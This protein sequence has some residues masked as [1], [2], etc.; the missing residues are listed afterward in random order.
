MWCRTAAVALSCVF[1]GVGC[2]DVVVPSGQSAGSCSASWQPLMA[3]SREADVPLSY[4]DGN[5][6]YWSILQE[7]LVAL[8]VGGGAASPI[9]PGVGRDLVVEGN[10]FL[11]SSGRQGLQFFQA[12]LD[13]GTPTLLVD[14]AAGQGA[15][16]LS[17]WHAFT[18]DQIFWTQEDAVGSTSSVWH[19]RRDGG[20]ADL[21]ERLPPSGADVPSIPYWTP[22]VALGQDAVL[23]GNDGGLGV[24]VPFDGGPARA[25]AVPPVAS[26]WIQVVGVDETGV[27]WEIPKF[28]DGVKLA[29]TTVVLS[30][31]DGGPLRTFWDEVPANGWI[32]RIWP[33][34]AG[35]WIMIGRQKLDDDLRHTVVYA[36]DGKDAR[37][38][39]CSPDDS[40]T[41]WADQRV[42]VTPDAVYLGAS[43]LRESTWQVVRVPR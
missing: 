30:P 1:V 42:A 39:G 23:F 27:Y 12:P 31:A 38:L 4:S 35:G 37:R 24:A 3:P 33:D 36:Y 2:A 40:S 11:F 7:S 5:L 18:S 25:L 43:D 9:M 20:A 16:A 28:K 29:A 6:Y 17:M 15:P 26:Q 19:A 34:G 10:H 8:P 22:S 21:L 41:S 32:D 14:G 13:G